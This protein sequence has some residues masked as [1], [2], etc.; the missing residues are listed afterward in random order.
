MQAAQKSG[1][2]PIDT[3]HRFVRFHRL[4]ERGFVEFAFGI[5]SRDLMVDLVLPLRAYHEFCRTNRVVYLT[6]EEGDALDFE[7]AKWKY[8]KA[9]VT[10]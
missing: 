2:N 10:E 4:T 1:E 3:G 7:Q 6:R 9:G 8:G 5:G